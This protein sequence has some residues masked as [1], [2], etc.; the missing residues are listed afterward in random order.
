MKLDAAAF[1]AVVV[2]GCANNHLLVVVVVVVDKELRTIT[3]P[4][5]GGNCLVK[6]LVIGSEYPPSG[7]DSRGQRLKRNFAVGLAVSPFRGPFAIPL[8]KQQLL[9]L[10]RREIS[11]HSNDNTRFVMIIILMLYQ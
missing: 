2:I 1:S 9:L 7:R 4:V 10:G 11:S 8:H 5:L 6:G 3:S